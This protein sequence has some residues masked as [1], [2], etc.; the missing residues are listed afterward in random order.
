MDKE[1]KRNSWLHFCKKF[2]SDNQYREITIKFID[3][4][5]KIVNVIEHQ[6]LLGLSLTKKGRLIDGFQLYSE[7]GH[8]ERVAAPVAAIKEP[9]RVKV[10]LDQ[11]GREHILMIESE[12]G[13]RI[14]I[15][16]YGDRDENRQRG[17]V[18]KVAYSMYEKR[19][20]TPGNQETDW[21]EA[22]R[23]VRETE[24]QFV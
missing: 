8:V 12:D 7:W 24:A 21:L 22:E 5:K 1:I 10:G 13:S 6:P 3:R 11:N 18:E 15:E 23:I 20:Y 17:L 9:K 19:G 14:D 4:H 16:L 2:S